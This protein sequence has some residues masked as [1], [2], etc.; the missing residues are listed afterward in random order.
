[1]SDHQAGRCADFRR[2]GLQGVDLQGGNLQ[3]ANFQEANLR[4]ADLRGAYLQGACLQDANLQETNLQAV[5]MI[6]ARISSANLRGANLTEADLEK[7]NLERA[8]LQ[9]ANIERAYLQDANLKF[10][11]ISQTSLAHIPENIKQKFGSTWLVV[12]KVEKGDTDRLII[13]SITFPPEYHEAGISILTYFG[14]ILRKKYPDTKAKIQIKQEGLRVTM[15]IEPD[16]GGEREIIE[17]ALDEYGLVVTGQ[18]TPEE[19]TDDKVLII[20]LRSELRIAQARI[21]TQKELLQDKSAQIDK[22]FFIVGNAVQ[23]K[24][25]SVVQKAA[26]HNNIGAN[27]IQSLV[28]TEQISSFNQ[29]WEDGMGDN[30]NI[31]SGRDTAVSKGH[32]TTT[33]NNVSQTMDEKA[34]QGFLEQLKKHADALDLKPEKKNELS[35]HIV[36]AEREMARPTPEPERVDEYLASIRNILDGVAGSIIASGLLHEIGK[37]MG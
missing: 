3:E 4:G 20:G 11:R 8:D 16:D 13:R 1:M 36:L 30:I 2:C 33:I 34:I 24:P 28:Q 14:T 18:K 12:D 27:E 6:D 10:I 26:P 25:V 21:E 15:I 22:L 37:L 31:K 29:N 17:K 23:S 7:A 9:N 32:G 35:D 19:F 5:N